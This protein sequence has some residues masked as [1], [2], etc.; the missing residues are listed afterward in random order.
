[1]IWHSSSADEV[2]SELKVD[3]NSGL[4]T[5]V[6]D[7]RLEKYGM[8]VV[9]SV[10]KPT[11][12]NLFLAQLKNKTLIA[13]I[14]ISF[15]S[16]L[17][18]LIYDDVNSF[19]PLLIIAIVVIN[20]LVCAYHIFNCDKTLE[21][22]KHYSNP[23]VTVLRDGIVKS[24]NSALLV[25][26]DIILLEEGD[27][28]P[29][30]AR[31]IESNEFRCNESILTGVEV[32]VEK[33][34]EF[35][36]EDITPI[37]SRSNL[38]FSGCSVI[39]GTA[40]AVVIATALNTEIGRTSA[41]LE[42]Q[43]QGKLPLQNQLQS[44][45]KITNLIIL[46]ICI[47]VFL[48]GMIQN[49]SS[50]QF[51]SMTLK[52]LMNS[53]A[54]G[55]AAIP[56]A[57]PAIATIVIAIGTHKILKDKIIIKD[58]KAA[59]LLGKTD[60]LCCDK[61][62]VLTHNKMKLAKIFDGKKLID[63]E[64]EGID[65]QA[66]LTIKIAT[67]CSTL[68]NDSTEHAI[69]KACLAYNSMSKQDVSNIF[70]HIAEIPFDSNRK[71]MTVITMINEKPF[72]IVK[73]AAESVVPKCSSADIEGILNVNEALASDEYRVVC[74]AIKPLEFIPANPQTDEIEKDLTFVGLLGLLDPPREGV[75]EELAMLDSAGIKTIMV[76]GDNLTTAKA[77]A[78]RIGILKDGTIAITGEE[79]NLLTDEEFAENIEN[80]SV[81]ARISSNDK[82]RIIKAWQQKGKSVTVTGDGVQDA[83]ALALADVGCAI[84]KFG[85]DVAKGNA[86]IVIQNNRFSSIVHAIKESR[87]LFS[88]V[89][90][91]VNYLFS[92]N[93]A[94]LL[95]VFFGMIIFGKMPVAAVQLLWINLLTDSA[96]AISLSLE[97]A[98]TGIMSSKRTVS[99]KVFNKK[100]I[101]TVSLQSVFI[102][103]ITII[104]FAI[105][106][107]FGA[108]TTSMTMAFATLG[109]AQIF[110]CYNNK[111]ETS[112]FNKN[113]FSNRLLNISAAIGIFII[114]FLIFTPAGVLF[115]LE[116][117]SFSKFIIVL[118]LSICVIPFSEAMK[119]LSKKI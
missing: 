37:E 9:S 16:F 109:F 25:P 86:D 80:Y 90:K 64:T 73:G 27:Y 49:F 104:A 93:F 13:L 94:E 52:M 45:S 119:L 30:D 69:E 60:V 92:S 74:L 106:R 97:S 22:I 117:L 62:G 100:S 111:F 32:P 10:E 14:I 34:E 53:V 21:S 63:L 50:G 77:I 59:E 108:D 95:A 39:H 38:I 118:L 115:G 99:N 29:A 1:M 12:L 58:A 8:N 40:K 28:I 68:N 96:P 51:A 79:L 67:A 26:G 5:G 71:T 102:A 36:L 110:H 87:G 23:S 18:S 85:A 107:D 46:I 3:K 105:G 81:F 65:E 55:V 78:R 54:L 47:L 75:V 20:A 2:L 48:I 83:D 44:I 113:I 61:T 116:A 35:V 31:I 33:N 17:V 103:L 42:Q 15:L 70:P 89:R 98:E 57:L 56:E 24:I 91:L 41:I 11:F 114:L 6:A 101:F 43:G 88:N 72:A 76:T 82:L 4:L 7:E 84:G 19:S 112:I 66:A